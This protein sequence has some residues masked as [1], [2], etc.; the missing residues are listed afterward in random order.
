MIAA[1]PVLFNLFGDNI[2]AWYPRNLDTVC[3]FQFLKEW[4]FD[5][6]F[7]DQIMNTNI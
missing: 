5:E 3:W 2:R 4:M 7:S 6:R 1:R